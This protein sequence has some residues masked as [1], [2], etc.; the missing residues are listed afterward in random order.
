LVRCGA[1]EELAEALE[2]LVA[3]AALRQQLGEAGRQR[4][5]GEFC[6]VDKLNLV[7][8]QYAKLLG[9]KKGKR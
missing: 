2:R 7:R 6:W 5:A 9:K 1:I 8:N 3:E 4:L